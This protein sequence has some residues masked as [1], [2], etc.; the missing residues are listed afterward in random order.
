MTFLWDIT[1]GA[2]EFTPKED[3][4]MRWFLNLLIKECPKTCSFLLTMNLD[5]VKFYWAPYMTFSNGIMGAWCV[6]S[7]NRIYIRATEQTSMMNIPDNNQTRSG[8]LKDVR[9]YCTTS[10]V[11][12]TNVGVTFIHEFI[13]KLQFHTNPVL[14]VL[15][16]LITLFVDRIPFLEQLGIEYDARVNSETEELKNFL[17]EFSTSVSGYFSSINAKLPDD[18]S[19]WLY[20]CWA[21]INDCESERS[22]KIKNL[23]IEYFN[24]L[25]E[26]V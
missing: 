26:D 17:N 10:S 7:P 14:Y 19:N 13:H 23:T 21:G 6:T 25:N 2:H 12:E 18:P 20:K 24:L 11:F 15:N 5:K 22:E 16:R 1:K 9:T 4:I 3:K 8:Y